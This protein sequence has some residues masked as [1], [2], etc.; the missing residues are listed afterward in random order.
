MGKSK[1][2]FRIERKFLEDEMWLSEPFTKAQA[3]IDMIGLAQFEDSE[4][5]VNG[6]YVFVP[7]GS[8]RTTYKELANR[9]KWSEKRV[10]AF[11]GILVGQTMVSTQGSTQGTTLTIENYA[12]YQGQGQTQGSMQGSTRGA[13]KGRRRA[14]ARPSLLLYEEC[15]EGE[16]GK[17][18]NDVASAPSTPLPSKNDLPEWLSRTVST[19]HDRAD[20]RS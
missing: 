2:W 12:K 19:L 3:W 15:K 13:E 14:N 6:K 5:Y 4:I 16:E 1:G 7:R 20:G 10:R 9:W 17:K 18:E 8:F 11:I